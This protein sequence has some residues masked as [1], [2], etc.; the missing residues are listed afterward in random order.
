M[1]TETQVLPPILGLLDIGTSK[2]VCMMLARR[3]A[4]GHALIGVGHQISRGL[5][6]SVIVDADAAE[7][8]VRATIA[9]AEHMA[10]ASL[11]EVIVSAACGRFQS[12]HITA[13]LDLAGRAVS[14]ADVDRLIQAGRAHAERDDRA[15]MHVNQVAARLDGNP[16]T[17]D[18]IGRAGSHLALDVHA[19]SADRVPIRHLLHIT[20]RCQLKVLAIAPA[21]LASALAATTIEDRHRGTTVIDFGAGTTSLAQFANGCLVAIHVIPI[22][23]NHLT[24]DLTK[25]LGTSISEA[26]RIKRNYARVDAAHLGADDTVQYQSGGDDHA[27]T[28]QARAA[29]ISTIVTSRIDA[30][31]RQVSERLQQ[32]ASPASRRGELVLTG[33]GSLLAGLC[34]RTATSL[35]RSARLS[36]PLRNDYGHVALRHPQFATVAGLEAFVLDRQLGLRLDAASPVV[37]PHAEKSSNNNAI[38]RARGWFRQGF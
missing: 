4:A 20:E 12:S 29:D 7:D 33:G 2:I 35:E 32:W 36:A 6:A 14:A 11:E 9:Q 1:S 10:G 25:A 16:C 5:K 3:A 31:L 30:L 24:Y 18:S 8:A 15:A 23:G 28:R 38:G 17:N 19:V 27:H 21:P 37:R 26:E 22:G 13:G 34:E